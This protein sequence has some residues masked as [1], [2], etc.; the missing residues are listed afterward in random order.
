M[1]LRGQPPQQQGG[2]RPRAAR[3]ARLAGPGRP[4]RPGAPR[5][6]ARRQAPR[7]SSSATPATARCS[8]STSSAATTPASPRSRSRSAYPGAQAMF[9]AGCGADQNPLPRRTVEL[10]ERLRQAARRR[11]SARVLGRPMRPIEGPLAH[12]PTRRSTWPS[13]PCPT[14]EQVEQD[15][16]SSDFFIASRAKHL[17]EQIRDHGPAR[18]GL[19][20]SRPGLAARRP[21]LGLPRRRGRRRLLACGSS[22]TS[23]ARTPGSRPTATT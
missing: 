10:A 2:R 20:L 14:R 22:G 12:R 15:A 13:A 5:R 23:A 9:V 18:P 4:R 8:T 1:R 3:A 21:D 16:T 7:P 17:L 11:A 6:A 19:S